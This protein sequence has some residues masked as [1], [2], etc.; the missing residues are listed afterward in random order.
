MQGRL[1]FS[2][3][4]SGHLVGILWMLAVGVATPTISG[5][6]INPADLSESHSNKVAQRRPSQVRESGPRHTYST[7]NIVKVNE[8]RDCYGWFFTQCC[9]GYLLSFFFFFCV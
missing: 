6:T 4:G 7:L 5:S 1:L 3:A 8:W 9:L 2:G